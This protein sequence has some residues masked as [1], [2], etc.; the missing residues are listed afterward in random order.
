MRPDRQ[1]RVLFVWE[2]AIRQTGGYFYSRLLLAVINGTGMYV[3]LRLTNV[4]FAAPLA[5][6]EGIVAE[7]IPIVGTYIGGAVPILVAFLA[8]TAGLASPAAGFWALGYV[9]VYQ[10]IENYL[11]SPRITAK[12]MSL[13]P[14]VAFAAALIGG[15]LGGLFMAFLA[16][17]VAGVIQASVREWSKSY[18]VV[19]DD[20]KPQEAAPKRTGLMERMRRSRDTP[21]SHDDGSD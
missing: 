17:P 15:A 18:D 3:T 6:F 5:I 21:P 13:H 12:T 19:R 14:A 16:L 20:L 7:F 8:S 4:P 10:Q 9:L 2:Q 1:E 11:L